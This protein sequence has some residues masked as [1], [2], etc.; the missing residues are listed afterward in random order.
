MW[1][2]I[3]MDSTTM[4]QIG[5]SG[6]IVGIVAVLGRVL[7]IVNHRTLR[8]RCCGRSAEI[9]IDVDTP[10]VVSVRT[11]AQKETE[12]KSNEGN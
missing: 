2:E 4:A 3:V 5:M 11:P 7:Q 8:S 10:V 6:G 9:G 1:R 12:S